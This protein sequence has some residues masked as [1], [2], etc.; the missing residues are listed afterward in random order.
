M[1]EDFSTSV[2]KFLFLYRKQKLISRKIWKS[3]YKLQYFGK[4]M[5]LNLKK[6]IPM[7]GVIQLDLW[8]FVEINRWDLTRSEEHNTDKGKHYSLKAYSKALKRMVKLVVW[9]PEDGSARWQLYFCTNCEMTGKDIIDIY[10]TKFQIEFCLRD[11]KQNAGLTHCQSTSVNKL[12]FNFNA[13]LTSI[14]LAKAA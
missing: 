2:V 6:N 10:T 4:K 5:P 11:A 9:Y 8:N 12:A 3:V 13:S 14:N 7:W 1:G